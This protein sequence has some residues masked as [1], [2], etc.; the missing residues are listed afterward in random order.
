MGNACSEDRKRQMAEYKEKGLMQYQIVSRAM[1]EKYIDSQPAIQA[2][3][4]K[5]EE[6]RK[7]AMKKAKA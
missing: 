3:M 2:A 6:K 7:I 4:V 1:K 5:A